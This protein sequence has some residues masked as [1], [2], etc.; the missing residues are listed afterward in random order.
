[1]AGPRDVLSRV[2]AAVEADFLDAGV[3][4]LGPER[5]RRRVG[6]GWACVGLAE[7]TA[8]GMPTVNPLTSERPVLL[9]GA[10]ADAG[11][12]ATSQTTRA[13]PTAIGSPMNEEKRRVVLSDEDRRFLDQVVAK[14]LAQPNR[15]PIGVLHALRIG[16]EV[17]RHSLTSP[18]SALNFL[19]TPVAEVRFQI[20]WHGQFDQPNLLHQAELA[21]VLEQEYESRSQAVDAIINYAEWLARTTALRQLTAEATY[22]VSRGERTRV[23]PAHLSA[24][25]PRAPGLGYDAIVSDLFRPVF[26]TPFIVSAPRPDWD[27]RLW[28]EAAAALRHWETEV[29]VDEAP[30]PVQ[31]LAL[32]EPLVC[33]QDIREAYFPLKLWVTLPDLWRGDRAES[34]LP[35]LM[36][37]WTALQQQIDRRLEFLGEVLPL[38]R[39]GRTGGHPPRG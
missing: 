30:A 11:T 35:L 8:A 4:A 15:H 13:A 37:V 29:V 25:A 7:A 6:Q 36:G 19:N 3:E 5:R 10:E 2:L 1:M 18:Q 14:T 20:R 21:R 33:D 38:H 12:P 17:V 32:I 34:A 26:L 9:T 27:A 24:T 28:R 23:I 16:L 39:R 31:V 22:R